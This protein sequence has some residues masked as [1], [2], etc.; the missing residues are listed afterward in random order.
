MSQSCHVITCFICNEGTKGAWH[1]LIRLLKHRVKR[2]VRLCHAVEPTDSASAL[3]PPTPLSLLPPPSHSLI[4]LWWNNRQQSPASR[5]G[6]TRLPGQASHNQARRD[7]SQSGLPG[8]QS[9][10]FCLRLDRFETLFVLAGTARGHTIRPL[11]A[12]AYTK[13]VN[14]CAASWKVFRKLSFVVFSLFSSCSSLA[15]CC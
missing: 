8:G 13:G 6:L 4:V 14:C 10:F 5:S 7:R 9:G 1:S 3:C 2:L 15:F 11:L 12:P